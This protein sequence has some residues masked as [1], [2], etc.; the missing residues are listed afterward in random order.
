MI[1]VSKIHIHR[2]TKILNKDISLNVQYTH[3]H[4]QVAVNG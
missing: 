4:K 2:Y 3:L 1:K